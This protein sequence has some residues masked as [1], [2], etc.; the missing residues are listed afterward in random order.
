MDRL[1]LKL[2]KGK[3][4]FIGIL[5]TGDPG[6]GK[7][8][9]D[10]VNNHPYAEYRIEIE[11]FSKHIN[12]RLICEEK[13]IIR[14]YAHVKYE[15]EE[16]TNWQYLTDGKP[17]FNFAHLGIE[18]D[19]EFVL[20]TWDKKKLFVLKVTSVQIMRLKEEKLPYWSVR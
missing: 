5:I 13:L 2:P 8:N 20:K 18:K 7:T 15:P 9:Q 4:P 14:H 3:L 16:L 1:I 12:M 10:L 6:S 11:V 19:K 17:A